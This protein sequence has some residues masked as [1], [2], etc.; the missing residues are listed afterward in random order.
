MEATVGAFGLQPLSQLAW[1]SDQLLQLFR[2]FTFTALLAGIGITAGSKCMAWNAPSILRSA[3]LRS[4]PDPEKDPSRD[5]GV[6]ALWEELAEA[7]RRASHV[8]VAGHS[9]NDR[10]LT[11]ALLQAQERGSRVGVTVHN[12]LSPLA[13]EE[14]RS[15]VS[16]KLPEAKF[17]KAHIGPNFLM[18]PSEVS[19]WLTGR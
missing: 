2:F 13:A 1:L 12:G 4:M 9:L 18:T 16:A 5:A 6:Q 14:F 15:N 10:V 11:E 19:A 8:L 3:S 7:L 17:I